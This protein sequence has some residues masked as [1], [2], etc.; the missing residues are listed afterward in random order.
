M[1]QRLANPHESCMF[2]GS[3]GNVYFVQEPFSY[4][5]SGE[6][7]LFEG[8]E[9]RD[10]ACLVLTAIERTMTLLFERRDKACL[11]STITIL[12]PEKE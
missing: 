2:E 8:L 1:M 11:V 10:K 7:P 5:L 4:S 12:S 6:K 3:C 9:R